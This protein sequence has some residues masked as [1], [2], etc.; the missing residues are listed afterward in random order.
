M[1]ELLHPRLPPLQLL[2]FDLDGTLIDSVPDLATAVDQTLIQLGLPAAGEDKVRQWVGNGSLTLLQRALKGGLEAEAEPALPLDA[3]QLQQAHQ[4]FLDNYDQQKGLQTRLYP[5][6]K[7]TLLTLAASDLKLALVTNKPYRF[8]PDL[9]QHF[10]LDQV[11]DQVLGGDSLP[12]RKPDPQPLLHLAG[13]YQLQPAHC[14]MIGDSRTDIQAARAAGFFSI[15]L[16]YGYNH[17][18]PLT[19]AGPDMMIACLSDL[20]NPKET[21]YD[22]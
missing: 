15:G 3:Q 2:A 11:F 13:L 7:E 8:V 22:T 5:G 18:E 6:V 14:A 17:G 16:P 20:L 21:L 9:L 10:G 1:S 4:L 12:T 19:Q